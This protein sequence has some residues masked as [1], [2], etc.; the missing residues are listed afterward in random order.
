MLGINTH[1][2]TSVADLEGSSYW[3]QSTPHT[4]T[5]PTPMLLYNKLN[6]VPYH[7]IEDGRLFYIFVYNDETGSIRKDFLLSR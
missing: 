3:G 1:I 6:K 7:E 4:N 5:P 2:E